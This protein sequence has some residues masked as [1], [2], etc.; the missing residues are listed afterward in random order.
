MNMTQHA[1]KRAQQRGI[2]P[3]LL[4]LLL[5]F[6]KS[7]PAGDGAAKIY[8]DKAARRRVKAYVGPLGRQIEQFLNVYAV[9]GADG[10]IITT[11]H[12]TERVW[13]H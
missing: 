13:R 12:L 5:D 7:E 6:G 9:V 4:N 10:R 3:I 1:S 8:F 11:A 2:P